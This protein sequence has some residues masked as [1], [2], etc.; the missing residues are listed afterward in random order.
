[1][2]VAVAQLLEQVLRLPQ[3]SQTELIEALLDRAEPS[4]EFLDHQLGIVTRRMQNVRGGSSTV[5]PAEDAHDR[6]LASLRLRV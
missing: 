2:S 4:R 1:M 3:E 6:I 5:V